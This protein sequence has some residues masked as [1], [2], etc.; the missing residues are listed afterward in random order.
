MTKNKIIE[1]SQLTESR[2]KC[3]SFSSTR[4]GL[5]GKKGWTNPFSASNT[6][7]WC[8]C[9]LHSSNIRSSA[10]FVGELTAFITQV[11][12]TSRRTV[13]IRLVCY[14]LISDTVY[15]NIAVHPTALYRARHD[16]LPKKPPCSLKMK[17]KIWT[18]TC[19]GGIKH[20]SAR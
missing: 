4:Q 11:D 15:K 2:M 14:S 7:G 18:M 13:L 8:T 3:D 9:S 10:C 12:Q 5:Q 16:C 19:G 17:D 1:Q 6:L 20:L